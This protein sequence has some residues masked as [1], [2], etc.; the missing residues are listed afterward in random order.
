MVE[1]S[2][3]GKKIEELV[4]KQRI[5]PKVVETSPIALLEYNCYKCRGISFVAFS[6]VVLKSQE[7]QAARRFSF[8]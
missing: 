1:I 6:D 2:N 7:K 5:H 3:S 8:G 4:Q